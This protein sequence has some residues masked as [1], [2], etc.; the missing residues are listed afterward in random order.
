MSKNFFPIKTETACQLKW[1]WSTIF[2]NKGTTR[3]CHRTAE[4]DIDTENFFNFHNTSLKIADREAMLKGVWPKTSCTYCKNI[5]ENGGIS[6]RI[7]MSAIPGLS[8]Q[9]LNYT[10]QSTTI[11]PTLLEVYFNNTCNLKC[12]YCSPHLSSSIE[13]ENKKF[14]SYPLELQNLDTESNRQYKNLVPLFWQWFDTGFTKLKRLHVAGG[15]P[16]YQKELDQLLEK[17]LITPN[18][19][20][21][22]NIITNLMISP[23]KLDH[24]I[25]KFQE[26]LVKRC[27]KKIDIT[28]SIDSWGPEQEYVRTGID[29]ELWEKNFLKLLEQR[30]LTV[31]INQTITPLTIKSMPTLLHKL[32]HWR[33]KRPVGHF[34]SGAE[35]APEFLK[36]DFFGPNIFEQDIVDIL[37]TMPQETEQDRLALTYMQGILN[38]L[39]NSTQNFN[40]IEKLIIFLDEIDRRRDLNWKNV[41]PWL[42][43]IKHVV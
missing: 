41:F 22:F 40:K 27:L 9:E 12:V 36:L 32:K 37:N 30:W 19:D 6:D 17:I 8:P 39:S 42:A 14:G 3:S 25:E 43:E 20:C 24:Y 38:Q 23:D 13:Q 18:A 1:A 35:P 15:E 10:N 26:L 34:F 28:C 31:N 29:L 33:T 11:N 7:R 16:F 5:E 21:E 4:S 2:L